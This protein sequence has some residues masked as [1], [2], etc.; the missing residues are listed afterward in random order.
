M[1]ITQILAQYMPQIMNL[2]SALLGS[3]VGAFLTLAGNMIFRKVQESGHISIYVR[4]VHSLSGKHHTWG[5]YHPKDS[6]N[7]LSFHIPI[8]FEVVNTCGVQRVL[9]DVNLYIYS[10]GKEVMPFVQ[11][12]HLDN[13]K[14]KYVLGQNGAYT[15]VI[16]EKSSCRFDM[17]FFLRLSE[18]PEGHTAFDKIVLAYYDERDIFHTFDFATV[19]TCWTEGT[20]RRP[21][22][23][24]RLNEKRVSHQ[25][26]KDAELPCAQ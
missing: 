7:D 8:W 3:L 15:V 16:P 4:I 18:M 25:Q 5:F 24:F 23:W 9:R 26:Q 12:Q 21:K 20:L 1:D 11:S 19:K 2:V 10:N 22:V 14:E 6:E 13:D 17:E